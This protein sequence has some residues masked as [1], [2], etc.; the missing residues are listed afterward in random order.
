MSGF[1]FGESTVWVEGVHNLGRGCT[2]SGSRV[3]T[4][5][6]EG[7]HN[8][9]RGCTQ[10]ALACRL[11]PQSGSRVHTI[12][13]EGVHNLSEPG[14]RAEIDSPPQNPSMSTGAQINAIMSLGEQEIGMES[15]SKYPIK[16]PKSPEVSIDTTVPMQATMPNR[17]AAFMYNCTHYVSKAHT[18]HH[19][20][21]TT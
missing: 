5:W 3:Y 2:Q 1:S 15:G 14:T 8:L 20:C 18:P 13:V 12:W 10:S 21:V 6:V 19:V 7:A 11:C 16:L 9:S 4:I 17:F